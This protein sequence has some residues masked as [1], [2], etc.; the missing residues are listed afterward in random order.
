MKKFA[1]AVLLALAVVAVAQVR[2]SNS[3]G[4]YFDSGIN[5]TNL[6]V[7]TQVATNLIFALQADPTTDADGEMAADED[8][9]GSGF[10][11]LEWFNGTA[12][13]RFVAVTASDTPSNGQVPTFNTD[14][15]ITWETVSGGSGDS[16]TIDGSAVDTT[17]AFASSGGIDFVFADG[18]EGGPDAVTANLNAES[19]DSDAFV[20]GGIDREHLSAAAQAIYTET[21]PDAHTVSISAT[22]GEGYGSVHYVS[23]TATVTLPAVT[24]GCSFTF[25]C[26]GTS[27]TIDA[28]ASDRIVLDGTA[29][30]DGDSIDSAGAAG[31]VV[32]ITYYDADGWWATSNGWTDGG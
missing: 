31:D 32:T 21:T 23:N 10:D 28:N 16:I 7:E 18:G 17:A 3:G 29:L 25:I 12:S 9:W 11:A 20:D 19:V 2:I 8:G 15:E 26:V 4:V 14:G 22:T 27:A 30:D 13:A 5:I 1:V 24:A 6:N